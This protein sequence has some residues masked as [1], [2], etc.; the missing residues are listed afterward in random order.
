[1]NALG[2]WFTDSTPRGCRTRAALGGVVWL[3][4][5]AGSQPGWAEALLLLAPLVVVPLGLALLVPALPGP[6]TRPL[7]LVA[8]TQF[9]AALLL[10]GVFLLPSGLAAA[11]LT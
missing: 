8:L 9:P 5:V 1:M 6:D 11:A 3:A 4:V 10:S 7:R 2:N